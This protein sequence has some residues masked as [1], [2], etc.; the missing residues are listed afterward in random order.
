MQRLLCFYWCKYWCAWCDD[1]ETRLFS[2]LSNIFISV[3]LLCN[4]MYSVH[5]WQMPLIAFMDNRAH[6]THVHIYA[7]FNNG[8]HHIGRKQM[9]WSK[10]TDVSSWSGPS[11]QVLINA[12][13]SACSLHT[14]I[15]GKVQSV[16]WETDG[17]SW[18]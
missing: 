9:Q 10:G 2:C 11:S 4:I 6:L 5:G 3:S 1:H 15:R 18:Q 12:Y 17:Q 7:R 13:I 16:L 8:K 14:S